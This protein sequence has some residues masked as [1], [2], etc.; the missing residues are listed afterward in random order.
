MTVYTGIELRHKIACGEVSKSN[1]DDTVDDLIIKMR[2]QRCKTAINSADQRGMLIG[3]G[4][5]YLYLY[6][7][8]LLT[9]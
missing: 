2:K 6:S 5:N 9:K 3:I 8:G 7:K 4:R 1:L